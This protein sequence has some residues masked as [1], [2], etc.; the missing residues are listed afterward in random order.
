ME[1]K[2]D[3][4]D[5][6]IILMNAKLLGLVL[7]FF[8]GAGLFLV[9]IFLVVKGGLHVGEHLDLLSN[10]FPGYKVTV[11]GAFIGFGY[12]FV[13]GFISGWVLGAVYNKFARA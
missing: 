3:Q 2:P 12:A 5:R 1:M 10:F 9:T 8:S 6:A 11:L 13:M 7:G 4:L